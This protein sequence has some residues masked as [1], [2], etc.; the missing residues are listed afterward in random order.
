M[1][2]ENTSVER[3]EKM[4]STSRRAKDTSN[5]HTCSNHAHTSFLRAIVR[6]AYLVEVVHEDLGGNE[7]L[8]ELR[9]ELQLNG[10]DDQG[11]G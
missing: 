2:I 9:A 1:L 5:A 7:R 11:L 3:T 6:K 8:V 4:K 10:G